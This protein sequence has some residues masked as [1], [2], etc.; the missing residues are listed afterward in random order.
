MIT[1][2]ENKNDDDDDAIHTLLVDEDEETGVAAC[3]ARDSLCFFI[4]Q[5]EKKYGIAS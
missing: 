4:E 5:C 2:E 3:F 1:Y